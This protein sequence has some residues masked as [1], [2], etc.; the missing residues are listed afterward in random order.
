M[1]ASVLSGYPSGYRKSWITEFCS[2][3]SRRLIPMMM[4]PFWDIEESVR[5]MRRAYE[6]G[7]KGVLL[8]ARY[9]KAGFPG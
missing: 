4:L 6:M 9:D 8:A 5:E 1:M 7:Q 2:A 3:D